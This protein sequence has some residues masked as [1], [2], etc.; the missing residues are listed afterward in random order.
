MKTHGMSNTRLYNIYDNM[1][2]RCYR[3]SNTEYKRYGARGITVCE[4][5]LDDFMNFYNWAINNGYD[6]NLS[7]DRIDTNGNYEPSNCRWATP[8][9]QANN[10]RMTKFITFNGVKHSISEWADITGIKPC[11]IAYRLRKN[12]PTDKI[13]L[14]VLHPL[15][16]GGKYNG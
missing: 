3:K 8:R 1:K 14:N 5:W 7:I 4:E 12:Y 11:T 13:L 16:K 10:T 2:S 15:N 9:E 6:D